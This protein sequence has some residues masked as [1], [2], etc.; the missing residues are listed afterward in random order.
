MAFSLPRFLRRTAPS[1]LKQYFEAQGIEFAAPI[2]WQAGQAKFIGPL[3]AAIG[4]LPGEDRARV[5]GDFEQAER[6]CDEIGQRELMRSI[7]DSGLRARMDF[8]PGT[9]ARALLVLLTN[10]DAFARALDAAYA[11]S[12][13]HGRSWSGY[14]LSAQKSPSVDPADL[15]HLEEDLKALFRDFDGSARKLKVETF[16]R[17]VERRPDGTEKRV[18]HYTVYIE[19]L[20]RTGMEFSRDELKRVT[21]RPAAEAAICCDPAAGTLEI[22]AKGGR[23]LREEMARAFSMHM[24][25]SG[26]ELAPIPQRRFDLDRL[27]SMKAFPTDP[28]DGI[29]KVVVLSLRLRDIDTTAGQV[30]ID[31]ADPDRETIYSVSAFWFGDDD[32]LRRP[33]CRVLH[34]KLRITFHPERVGGRPK[35]ITVE[36]RSPNGSNLRDQTQRHHLIA[37][38]YLARWGLIQEPIA[39]AA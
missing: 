37:E 18:V 1:I 14:R 15:A 12:R 23:I 36:L 35:S 33:E 10:R 39:D 29:A 3:A 19:E 24:L 34:A 38:K 22:V 5:L 26:A 4:T 6:L 8:C 13:R 2:N 27:M 9:E 11:E 28:A 32:P 17:T 30:T 20:P 25:K 21:R 7:A 16:E 31:V